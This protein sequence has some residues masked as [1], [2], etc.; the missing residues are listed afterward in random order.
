MKF[1]HRCE[2]HHFQISVFFLF[3]FVEIGDIPDIEKKT[4]KKSPKLKFSGIKIWILFS[5]FV[6]KQFSSNNS[7]L[8]LYILVDKM[9]V[10]VSGLLVCWA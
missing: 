2:D 6:K 10:N 8:E 4:S 1:L 3:F 9:S 7:V 5:E